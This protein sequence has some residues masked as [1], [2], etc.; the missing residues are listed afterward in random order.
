VTARVYAYII[1]LSPELQLTDKSEL[2]VFRCSGVF[3]LYYAGL[4]VDALQAID[5]EPGNLIV[6]SI[7]P[8]SR[9]GHPPPELTKLPE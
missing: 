4:E 6:N 3:F 2:V 7:P 9:M 8:A 1:D 5:L